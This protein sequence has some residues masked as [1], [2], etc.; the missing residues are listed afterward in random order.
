LTDGRL[1]EAEELFKTNVN[2]G[3]NYSVEN[4]NEFDSDCIMWWLDRE[5]VYLQRNRNEKVVQ[6]MIFLTQQTKYFMEKA[7]PTKL[8]RLV[9]M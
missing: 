5:E 6:A 8:K 3:V 4:L 7:N 1:L 9:K 2:V